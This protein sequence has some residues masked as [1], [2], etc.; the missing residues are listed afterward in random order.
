MFDNAFMGSSLCGQA[1]ED[2][3]MDDDG[4][5]FPVSEFLIQG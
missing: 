2:V 3:V 1:C 4:E 5:G